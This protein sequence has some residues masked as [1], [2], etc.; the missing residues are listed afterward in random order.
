MPNESITIFTTKHTI[1][2][3]VNKYQRRSTYRAHRY[4]R[5]GA[6]N[7]CEDLFG[8]LVSPRICLSRKRRKKSA[9]NRIATRMQK[10]IHTLAVSMRES[11]CMDVG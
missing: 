7:H 10:P 2:N 6:Y 5:H 8:R 9:L 1:S 11:L 4:T 3:L